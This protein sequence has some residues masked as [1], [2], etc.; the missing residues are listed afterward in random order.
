MESAS[1]LA[2]H[3]ARSRT[4]PRPEVTQGRR[5]YPAAATRLPDQPDV[6]DG[7]GLV[8]R[9]HH[10]VHGEGGRLCV[11][12]FHLRARARPVHRRFDLE[13][14]RRGRI[15]VHV[16]E[17]ADGGNRVRGALGREHPPA[18][19]PRRCRPWAA[20]P[21]ARSSG[22]RGRWRIGRARPRLARRDRLPGHVHHAGAR[23]P[24]SGGSGAG[25]RDAEILL[26][27]RPSRSRKFPSRMAAP[28]PRFRAQPSVSITSSAFARAP[29]RRRS[30][31][32][33]GVATGRPRAHARGQVVAA[34]RRT[35]TLSRSSTS[36]GG[37]TRARPACAAGQ[38]ARG[39]RR[40]GRHGVAGQPELS[41]SPR[42]ERGRWL[43][44]H[45][46]EES[47]RRP[48]PA[49]PRRGQSAR[50]DPPEM[51]STSGEPL[52]HGL[53]DERGWSGTTPSGR[54]PLPAQRAC[55]MRADRCC[56]RMRPRP[57]VPDVDS[58]SLVIATGG[59]SVPKLGAS[60]LGYKVAEQFGLSIV[61]PR[62]STSSPA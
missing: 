49:P 59:L 57:G 48:G 56:C 32:R 43:D 58:A 36:T 1:Q 37:V 5:P 39:E 26:Q 31:P 50:G 23:P 45:L 47:P 41:L 42:R 35:P 17:G 11:Q 61:P 28:S 10:V 19:R 13:P 15:D 46:G 2:L 20:C 25:R 6:G 21:P 30:R 14:S 9:L 16:R 12:R 60:P 44:G 18:A 62:A 27:A 52:A 38:P 24:A 34:A 55:A 22:P 53:G 3:R 7:H 51:T 33:R 8:R 4:W 54:R 29:R 40:L